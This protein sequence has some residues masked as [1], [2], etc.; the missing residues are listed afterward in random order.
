MLTEKDINTILEQMS[1]KFEAN[2]VPKWRWWTE[3]E[4]ADESM[5][6]IFEHDKDKC[7]F[8]G[9]INT[10]IIVETELLL[11]SK[12]VRQTDVQLSFGYWLMVLYDK[13][14]YNK[15]DFAEAVSGFVID[16]IEE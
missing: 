15:G 10:E 4:E 7:K 16:F 3:E 8:T 2:E 5:C 6:W 11:F 13:D 14:R 12:D 1:R 9:D